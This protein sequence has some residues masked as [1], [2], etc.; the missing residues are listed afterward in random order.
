MVAAMD[1]RVG[2]T[3]IIGMSGDNLRLQS[4]GLSAPIMLM[5]MMDFVPHDPGQLIKEIFGKHV[6]GTAMEFGVDDHRL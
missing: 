4:T 3:R 1:G 6:R 5:R 2:V